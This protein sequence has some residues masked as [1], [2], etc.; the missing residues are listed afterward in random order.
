[1]LNFRVRGKGENLIFLHGFCEDLRIWDSFA[2]GFEGNFQV[3]CPDLP[4]FGKSAPISDDLSDWAGACFDLLD[5]LN[6]KHFSLIGHSMGGYV[7]LAMMEQAPERILNFVSFHSGPLPDSEEKKA[8]RLRQVAI[9]QERG[10][11]SYVNQLIP[12]LFKQGVEGPE[13]DT[14]LSIAREQSVVG[15]TSALR[16]MRSRP[17]RSKVLS[18]FDAPALI[19]SGR[20]DALLSLNDQEKIASSLKRGKHGVLDR[21]GHMG[22]FEEPEESREIIREFLMH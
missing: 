7:A 2:P 4:G 17:D 21:S 8:N 11:A 9:V 13:L 20:Y 6:I 19:L 3:C 14:C 5:S 16:A 1:M 22:F 10:V 18:G 12:T 15:I